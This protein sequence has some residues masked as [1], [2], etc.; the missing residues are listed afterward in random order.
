MLDGAQDKRFRMELL[1]FNE[2]LLM[3]QKYVQL[4]AL[5]TPW[6]SS[7]VQEELVGS[8]YQKRKKDKTLRKLANGVLLH[9]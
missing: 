5:W 1:K 4:K 8:S 6:L 3:R 9:S 2:K 7:Q